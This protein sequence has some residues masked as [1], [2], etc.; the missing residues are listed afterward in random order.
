MFDEDERP[1]GFNTRFICVRAAA[2]FGIEHSDYLITI[3]SMVESAS[4][5]GSSADR[6]KNVTPTR[7]DEALFDAIL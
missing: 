3:V 6:R 5:I 2:G 4:G 1:S 7:T